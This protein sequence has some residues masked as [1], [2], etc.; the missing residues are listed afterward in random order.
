MEDIK[1]YKNVNKITKTEDM[2]KEVTHKFGS[3]WSNCLGDI[4]RKHVA[5]KKPARVGSW[6]YNYKG[7]NSIALMAVADVGY[8]INVYMFM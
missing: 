6:Y 2:W 1:G 7:L 8:K 5:I 4:E 3:R